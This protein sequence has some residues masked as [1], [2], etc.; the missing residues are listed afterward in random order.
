MSF[1]AVNYGQDEFCR[2]SLKRA[3][4]HVQKHDR[5]AILL[6]NFSLFMTIALS[7]K[8]FPLSVYIFTE[9]F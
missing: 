1:V 5:S 4:I 6:F 9:K 2:R 3:D 8:P 7:I